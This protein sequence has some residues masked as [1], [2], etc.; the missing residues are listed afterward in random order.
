L[1]ACD[2]RH[3]NEACIDCD[4]KSKCM[5]WLE[6]GNEIKFVVYNESES[7]DKSIG[8]AEM[9]EINLDDLKEGLIREVGKKGLLTLRDVM[10]GFTLMK[11]ALIE[12]EKELASKSQLE[13]SAARTEL[14]IMTIEKVQEITA[15]FLGAVR[16]IKDLSD[17]TDSVEVR[18]SSDVLKDFNEVRRVWRQRGL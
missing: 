17:L 10:T 7:L 5:L 2:P 12:A 3:W 13:K 6:P 9:E 11:E 18:S 8:G 14:V 15:D 4:D 16:V 1:R